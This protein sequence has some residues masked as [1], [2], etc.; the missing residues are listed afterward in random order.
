[1]ALTNSSQRDMEAAS[2]CRP[3]ADRVLNRAGLPVSDFFHFA[4]QFAK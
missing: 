3:S 1:M 4:L 2:F